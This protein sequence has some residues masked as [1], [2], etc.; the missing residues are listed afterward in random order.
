MKNTPSLLI[1]D[2]GAFFPKSLFYFNDS[3]SKSASP[4]AK[5]DPAFALMSPSQIQ[6]P[7]KFN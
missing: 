7:K 1:E 5:F 4:A 6:L 3:K 2:N